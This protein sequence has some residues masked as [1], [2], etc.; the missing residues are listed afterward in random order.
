M[1]TEH[2][3]TADAIGGAQTNLAE[4]KDRHGGTDVVAAVLGALT[5]L[6]T[7]VLLGA[8]LTA[9]A[10]GIDYQPVLI[11]GDGN[12]E[13]VEVVGSLVAVAVVFASFLVGGFAAGRISRFDGALNGLGAALVFILVSGLLALAA[14]L[15][16]DEYN[17]L[18]DTGL[19]NWFAQLDAN[20]VTVKALAAAAAGMV[21]ALLGGYIGGAGGVGYN[22]EIDAAIAQTAS[23]S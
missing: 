5:A 17:A 8:F 6:G 11:D 4:V 12:L 1:T 16:G 14:V 9:G 10:A 15:F 3:S 7:M 2:E 18:I 21:A 19:P 20:D 22:R 23:T 13:T